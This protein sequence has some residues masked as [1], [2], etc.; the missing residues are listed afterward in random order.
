MSDELLNEM[1][2]AEFCGLENEYFKNLR[3]SGHGPTYVKPSERV[4]LY[5]KSDLEAW[6]AAWPIRS[7][8]KN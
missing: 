4:V 3:R 6:I 7:A 8:T 5:R 2:A 1:E